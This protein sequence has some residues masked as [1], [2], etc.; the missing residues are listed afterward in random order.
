MPYGS[1]VLEDL[2][3]LDRLLELAKVFKMDLYELPEIAST[4]RRL[5]AMSSS[6]GMGS[7]QLK[8]FLDPTIRPAHVACYKELVKGALLNVNITG[9]GISFRPA[10]ITLHS[11][12]DYDP[13]AFLG[14][15][16]S[17]IVPAWSWMGLDFEGDITGHF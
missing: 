6:G 1:E 3:S 2:T 16:H 4:I 8:H 14:I 15:P 13:A 17:T 9:F 5:D 7:V 11:Y 12:P 10:T